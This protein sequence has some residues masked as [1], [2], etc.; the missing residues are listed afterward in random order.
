M[1][2]YARGIDRGFEVVLIYIGTERVEINLARIAKRVLGGGHNV[3]EMDVRRRLGCFSSKLPQSRHPERSASQICRVIQGL[4]ARSRRTPAVLI[5]PMLF[6]A[7]QPPSPHRRG[8]PRVCL[9]PYLARRDGISH[10]QLSQF[11]RCRGIRTDH[12][13]TFY[14]R[15]LTPAPKTPARSSPTTAA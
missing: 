15:F 7:F 5:L 10:S 9:G 14:S 8:P 4:V 13:L 2:Q 3:P 6:G 11:A 1:M 12:I